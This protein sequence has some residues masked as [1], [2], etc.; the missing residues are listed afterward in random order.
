VSILFMEYDC[1]VLFMLLMG[2]SY[3]WIL[4]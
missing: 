2:Q 1:I 4:V 3:L